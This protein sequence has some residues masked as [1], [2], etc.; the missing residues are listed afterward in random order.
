VLHK[1][2]LSKA[3]NNLTPNDFV[4]PNN[5]FAKIRNLLDEK[6]NLEE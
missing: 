6:S 5:E 4:M 1:T 3:Y 2:I